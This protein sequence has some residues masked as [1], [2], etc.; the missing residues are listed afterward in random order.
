M[1]ACTGAQVQARHDV[2]TK[3]EDPESPKGDVK[4]PAIKRQHFVVMRHGERI[5][6]VR[7]RYYSFAYKPSQHILAIACSSTYDLS[8]GLQNVL[9][10]LVSSSYFLVSSGCCAWQTCKMRTAPCRAVSAQ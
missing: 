9:S 6:E 8:T 1:L 5:D 10:N 7:P 2:D 3:V 4:G